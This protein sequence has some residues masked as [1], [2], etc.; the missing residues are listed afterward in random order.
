MSARDRI[1]KIVQHWF[2]SEP[3]LFS[4]WTTH[5]LVIEPRIRTIRI[6][7]GRIE[8]NPSFIDALKM[9]QL[10]MVLRC[11]AIRILL[12]HPYGRRKENRELA[13]LASNVTLQEHL[14]SADIPFPSAR[15]LFGS[16][17]FDQQY[18]EYYY[19]KLQTIADQVSMGGGGQGRGDQGEDEEQSAG[20]GGDSEGGDSQRR[21]NADSQG[22]G[23]TDSRG[24]GEEDAGSGG[25]GKGGG[26]RSQSP[27]EIYADARKIGEENTQEWDS[28]E[29]LSDRINDKIRI[30]HE[31]NRWGSVAGK[32]R[33]RILAKLR[34]K[35][36]YRAV[37]RHFRA[38]IISVNRVLTRMK[39]S[40]RYGFLYMGSRRDFTTRL[41]F[42]VDVSGSVTSDD[43]AIGFS[44]VNQFFK[45]GVE[46]VDVI[47]FDTEIKGKPLSI[48]RARHEIA[49]MGRGGTCF[50][51]VISYID[52][53]REYDGLII[54]TDGYAPIPP[55]PKN[56]RTRILWLFNN[57]SNYRA[58]YK[59]LEP[60]GRSAFLKED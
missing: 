38:S 5:H 48:R 20:S 57:E 29:L 55:K 40:R 7:H 47:Q 37:L 4:V 49:I 8:Y 11:E 60:I 59:D 43:V 58:L 9:R 3:L 24:E 30:A 53:H 27:L 50:V 32:L 45:Y 41:L 51:P 31:S 10:K 13:Y 42:A 46:S 52:E 14:R 17:E 39:P 19:Y 44:I 16:D 15:D 1:S 36:N 21:G 22:E 54:F 6:R 2:L 34:P 18:F 35:L 25:H 28:D 23:D 26:R 12:K 56:T 33:E